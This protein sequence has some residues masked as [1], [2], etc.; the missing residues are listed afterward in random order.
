MRTVHSER[1]A[2]S[3]PDTLL[4]MEHPP[5]ITLGANSDT[6]G[7]L[8]PP[9]ILR[10]LSIDIVRVERGG[11]AT[12]HLP[13]QLVAYPI[14]NLR[15]RNIGVRA[16]VEALEETL[17]ATAAAFGLNAF[18]KVGAPGIYLEGSKLASLGIAVK[19]GVTLHGV[20]LNVSCDLTLFNH[21]VPCGQADTPP[22]SLEGALGATIP[23]DSAREAYLASFSE[24]F[25]EIIR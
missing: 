2:G 7:I 16:L 24:I 12:M 14:L 5:V 17:L 11:R 22:I 18:R 19:S 13:G 10:G 3:A 8:T 20:A 15:E 25:G 6:S 23:P 4:L 9:E 1:V 21:I